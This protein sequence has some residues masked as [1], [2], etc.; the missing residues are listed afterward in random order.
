MGNKLSRYGEAF[1]RLGVAVTTGVVDTVSGAVLY[2][3]STMGE[4]QKL[5]ADLRVILPNTL[6]RAGE[7]GLTRHREALF[8]TTYRLVMMRATEAEIEAA[9]KVGDAS[10]VWKNHAAGG[11]VGELHRP[12]GHVWTTQYGAEKRD[13]LIKFYNHVHGTRS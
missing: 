6:P 8:E 13:M 11:L 12:A 4:E 1:R 2:L 9:L 10:V 7:D 5:V 3:N